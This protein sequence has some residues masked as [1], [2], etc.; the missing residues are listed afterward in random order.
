MDYSVYVPPLL[1]VLGG[2]LQY[3]RSFGLGRGWTIISA[4]VL[5]AGAYLLVTVPGGDWRV[6]TL[7][8]LVKSY[9]YMAAIL[10]GT[11]LT[12]QAAKQAVSWGAD[13]ASRAVPNTPPN[14]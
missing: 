8:G 10:G 3:A 11:F 4:A 13:P 5:A 12:S 9:E 6:F 14:A 2:A 7:A 1:P